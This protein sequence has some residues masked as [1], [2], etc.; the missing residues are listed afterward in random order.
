MINN[1]SSNEAYYESEVGAC[2]HNT[3]S[4]APLIV[5]LTELG[6]T[7]PPTPLG[8]DSSTAFGIL[9]ETIKKK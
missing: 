1:I 8:T 9:N 2:F 6:H 3:Q 7:Q 4:G 5:T